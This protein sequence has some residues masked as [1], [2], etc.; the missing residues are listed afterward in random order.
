MLYTDYLRSLLKFT[1]L[2]ATGNFWIINQPNICW[3]AVHATLTE[4]KNH[5]LCVAY[6][7]KKIQTNPSL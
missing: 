7:A 3:A 2:F 1:T 4:I 5:I 6:F